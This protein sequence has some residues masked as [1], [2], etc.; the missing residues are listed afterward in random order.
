MPDYS[1][2]I[3]DQQGWKPLPVPSEDVYAQC[4]VAP[5]RVSFKEN[6]EGSA[7]FLLNPQDAIPIA[8]GRAGFI[9]PGTALGGIISLEAF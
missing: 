8:A 7:G 9:R 3:A 4:H 1:D 5:V 2:T 6:P